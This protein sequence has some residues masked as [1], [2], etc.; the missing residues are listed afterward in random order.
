MTATA[1]Y[2]GR[3]WPAWPSTQGVLS[4][5]ICAGAGIT[6]LLIITAYLLWQRYHLE[7][8]QQQQQTAIA[9]YY[10]QVFPN[11]TSIVSPR[12]RINRELHRVQQN[13]V[14]SQ[15]QHTI[16]LLSNQIA[17]AKGV[18]VDSLTFQN[19][20]IRLHLQADELA[21]LDRLTQQWQ[22][23]GLI[24]KRL[25]TNSTTQAVTLQLQIQWGQP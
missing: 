23:D 17:S 2:G 22:Q 19:N 5:K 20:V 6:S 10:R 1:T 9:S 25:A 13:Q 12:L 21:P 8:Y 7:H 4:D 18:K 3:A 24:I 11:A 15:L 14:G 16:A